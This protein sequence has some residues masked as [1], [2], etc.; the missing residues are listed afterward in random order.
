M[1]VLGCG[2]WGINHVRVLSELPQA[3][4][5]V[6]CDTRPERLD[7]VGR[8]FPTI[9]LTTQLEE[10]LNTPDVDAVV[11]STPATTHY[12]LALRC[13]NAGKHVLVEKPISKT[14]LEAEDLTRRAEARGL[15]LMVGHTFLYN[16]AV[17]TIKDYIQRGEV[18]RVYFVYARRT[19]MGPIRHDVNALWDLAP[20]DISIF[21]YL[22]G[23]KP[24]WV[25]AVGAKVLR[26]GREDVGFIS[27]GYPSNVVGHIQ[28]SWADAYKVREVVVVGSDRRIVFNDFHPVERV[29][30]FEKGVAPVE[31][32]TSFDEYQLRIRDGDIVSPAIET[33]EPLKN[34]CLH[35][36]ECV[37]DGKRPLTDGWAGRD[38]VQVMEAI[39]RSVERRGAPLEVAHE[40]QPAQEKPY[41][42]PRG[43]VIDKRIN[44]VM[45]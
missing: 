9:R 25:S 18:G 31:E 34:Q 44:T 27:L 42:A 3:R 32:A 7:E 28:V 30:V 35:F 43:K 29:R 16:P 11:I 26:N 4:I 22:L 24:E 2:Y 40:I 39:D 13:L 41:V 6:V 15:V 10:A 1:A 5:Q 23:G 21:N 33:S 8:R 19:N 17:R 37:R 38:V 14:V 12:A 36:V 45:P 20:H